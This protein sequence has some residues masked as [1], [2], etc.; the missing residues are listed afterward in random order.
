[1]ESWGFRAG[2]DAGPEAG[3][4]AQAMWKMVEKRRAEVRKGAEIRKR[5]RAQLHVFTRIYTIL[6]NVPGGNVKVGNGVLESWSNG[7]PE[8]LR[9]AKRVRL[10]SK[11]EKVGCGWPVGP[12]FP[13]S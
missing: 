11:W 4:P 5:G 7:V 1:M 3:V 12:A 8:G 13:T 9:R 6:H 2:E 10:F